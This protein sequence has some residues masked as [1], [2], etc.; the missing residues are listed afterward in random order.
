MPS[1]PSGS[2]QPATPRRRAAVAQGFPFGEKGTALRSHTF[3][4]AERWYPPTCRYFEP[5][6]HLRSLPR[7]V[8]RCT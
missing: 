1:E 5:A 2:E 6:L 3:V 7:H 8:W 4:V